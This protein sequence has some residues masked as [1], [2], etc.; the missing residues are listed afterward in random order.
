LKIEWGHCDPASI[1]FNSRYFEFA[2]SSTALLFE[3]ALQMTKPEMSE[4]YDADMPLVDASGRFI[5]PLK[6]AEVVEI[7]S[8]IREF[9]RSSFDVS[10]Q[11]FHHGELAAQVEETRVWVRF[12]PADRL[13][14]K[15]KPIP[16][17]VVERFNAADSA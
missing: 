15:S 16:A 6:L 9:R 17:E 1:V 4:R 14:I 2:D 12:D 13:K 11:F 3:A 7:V 8:T 10:H 5:K